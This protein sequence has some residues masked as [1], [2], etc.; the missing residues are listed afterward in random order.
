MTTIRVE[1]AVCATTADLPAGGLLQGAHGRMR[2]A[3]T[4][5]Y[6]NAS[7]AVHLAT[8]DTLPWVPGLTRRQR[9]RLAAGL[10]C[11]RTSRGAPARS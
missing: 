7:L 1:C 9:R 10:T 11:L 8:R 4:A 3:V 6:A 2:A 5:P